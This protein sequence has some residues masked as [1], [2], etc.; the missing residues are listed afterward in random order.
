MWW[1]A[2]G[3]GLM[4]A[5]LSAAALFEKRSRK[6]ILADVLRRANVAAFERASR[7]SL[8]SDARDN[9]QMS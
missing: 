5:L 8:N 9:I 3:G 1:L 7:S 4:M 6:L 2:K